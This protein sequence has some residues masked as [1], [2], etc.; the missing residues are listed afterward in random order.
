[1]SVDT[2]AGKWEASL[3]SFQSSETMGFTE[4]TESDLAYKD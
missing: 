2:V 3:E 4:T 1:M